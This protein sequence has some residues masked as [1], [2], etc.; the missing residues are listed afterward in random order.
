MSENNNQGYVVEGRM[1][2]LVLGWLVI[3][4]LEGAMVPY[5]RVANQVESRDLVPALR[6][7]KA[8]FAYCM[9]A[10]RGLRLPTLLELDGWDGPVAQQIEVVVLKKRCEYQICIKRKGRMRGQLHS[11]STP[12]MRV[13]YAPPE[14]F[15]ATR[16]VI[17]YENSFWED[18]AVRPNEEVIDQCVSVDPYWEDTDFD[19]SMLVDV[20]DILVSAF[21]RHA[22][23]VDSLMVRKQTEKQLRRLNGVRF[24]SGKGAVFVPKE[25]NGEETY[26]TLMG[27]SNMIA[28]FAENEQTEN[29]NYYDADGTVRIRSTSS[30]N[31]RPLGYLDGEK[32][33]EYIR[34]DIGDTLT[35]EMGE[36]WAK[37]V[38]AAETFNEENVEAFERKLSELETRREGLRTRITSITESIGGGVQVR[39]EMH[40]DLRRSLNQ[41]VSGMSANRVV[42]R[43]R[44]LSVI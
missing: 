10:V 22:T 39:S 2:E 42:Q 38:K 4:S 27:L 17:D 14:D 11:E 5:S 9:K 18:D 29:D 20:R 7:P 15:D 34:Q 30:S 16:W 13:S 37:V 19:V 28:S 3:W 35:M 1:N 41:R 25:V 6:R 26:P 40:S 24:S 8:A 32:E 36:Y 21:R 43:I 33:L 31:L 44:N 12:V 23:G